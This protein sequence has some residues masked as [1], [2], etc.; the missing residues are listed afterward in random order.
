MF[1]IRHCKTQRGNLIANLAPVCLTT[2]IIPF[3]LSPIC[4]YNTSMRDWKLSRGDPLCLSLSA[5]FR[6]G[7]VNYADDQ[8][9]DLDLLTA[10]PP[11]LMLRTTFGLRARSMRLFPRFSE[12]RLTVTD[13][14]EFSRPPRLRAFQPNFLELDFSPLK[15]LDVTADFR[16]A[17]SQVIAGRFTF[18]NHTSASR[19]IHLDLCAVLAPL[20]GQAFR[21][22]QYQMVNVL[23]GS[24]SGLAPL[25]FMTGSPTSTTTPFPSADR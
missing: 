1:L 4:P 14:A 19:K 5:D 21:P 2:K 17:G 25:L 11:A 8:T 24:T 9:W 12:D 6:F 16:A 15:D 18:F 23:A 22:S 13:P 20:D 3:D 10:E 7:D